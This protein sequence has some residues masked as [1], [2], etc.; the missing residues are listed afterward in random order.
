MRLSEALRKRQLVEKAA[1]KG[2]EDTEALQA[3][4]LFAQWSGEAV[5]EAGQRVRYEGVLYR[6]LQGHTAQSGWDPVSAP[7][8]WA[9]VLI[10]DESSIP[11]WEQPDSTNPYMKGD[12]VTHGGM[13]WISLLDDNIWEP[14]VYG[15]EEATV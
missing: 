15:W 7:S 13:M 5:Y 8:L 1:E 2:L 6:C 12:K 3:P 10:P 14:G 9:K 4:E 11:E